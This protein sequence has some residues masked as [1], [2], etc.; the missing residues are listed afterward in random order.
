MV[1]A[2]AEN[3]TVQRTQ[4]KL[5]LAWAF[6]RVEGTFLPRCYTT[7]MLED[8]FVL[9]PM[10]RLGWRC[11]QAFEALECGDA[12]QYVH[13]LRKSLEVCPGMKGMINFLLSNTPQLQEPSQELQMLAE[14][15]RMALARF[16]PSDPAV[17]L[18]KQSEA[19]RKVAHIIE[20]TPAVV[21][22]GQPQ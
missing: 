9:P 11:A 19:Y 14:Q 4:Q 18:L 3:A 15:L 16:D 6:A 8:P 2:G 13:L 5:D 7:E 12:A 22:G 20:G 17:A 21:W 10:H 1:V